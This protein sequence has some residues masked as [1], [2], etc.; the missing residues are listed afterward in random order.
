MSVQQQ[1]RPAAD[2]TPAPPVR[3]A[4]R[5]RNPDSVLRMY[6]RKPIVRIFMPILLLMIVASLIGPL[7]SGNPFATNNPP[8]I[9]PDSE[10]PLGTDN[11]GRDYLARVLMGGQVSLLV[12]FSVAIL[13]LTLALVVGGIAGFYGGFMDTI[14]VKISEFFQVIPGIILALVAAAILG[15]NVAIIVVIL[16]LTMWPGVARIVR[17]EAMRI[18]QLGYV[19][20]QRAAGFS[21]LRILWSDVLPNAMPPVLVATTMTVARAILAESG[22]SFLGIGD[23]NRPSWG[24]L[25]NQAQPYIST[26]WWLAF[27]PGLCIFLV[28]LAINLLGDALNDALNPSIGRVK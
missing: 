22:L 7:L 14:L 12:G 6:F 13:C 15:T 26:A 23:A 18:S 8:F 27:F 25:L 9:P 4:R 17:A 19:E 20:S 28:V 5:P 21:S 10:F 16:A 2:P 3:T 1:S 11:L 24:A